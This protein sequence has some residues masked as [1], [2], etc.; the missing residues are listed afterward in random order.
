MVR[1]E[2]LLGDEYFDVLDAWRK[3]MQH[4]EPVIGKETTRAYIQPPDRF[5]IEDLGWNR[6]IFVS[7]KG[8]RSA[9]LWNPWQER[10]LLLDQFQEDSW[11]NMVCLETARFGDDILWLAPGETNIMELNIAAE[12]IP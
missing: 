5:T 7:T 12:K 6:R 2:G 10:A 3:K 4:E 11:K 9:I 8:S 1:F